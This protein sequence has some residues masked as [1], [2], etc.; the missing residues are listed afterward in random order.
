[1]YLYFSLTQTHLLHD[2]ISGDFALPGTSEG[3]AVMGETD[4]SDLIA[5]VDGIAPYNLQHNAEAEAVDLLVE[6]QVCMDACLYS[7]ILLLLLNCCCD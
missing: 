5:I 4:V 2:Y 6:V 7:S 1:M 3:D